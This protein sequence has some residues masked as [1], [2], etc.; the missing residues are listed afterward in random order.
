MVYHITAPDM[1]LFGNYS[2][3]TSLNLQTHGRLSST[4]LFCEHRPTLLYTRRASLRTPVPAHATPRPPQG[5]Q[6]LRSWKLGFVAPSSSSQ[7]KII[8]LLENRVRE[9]AHKSLLLHTPTG[10]A[11]GTA[12]TSFLHWTKSSA[13]RLS[14]FACLADGRAS[15]TLIA[16]R[17]D[18]KRDNTPKRWPRMKRLDESHRT[19][20][21]TDYPRTLVTAREDRKAERG[22]VQACRRFVTES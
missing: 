12:S 11:I 10:S 9:S 15:A 7:L 21:W 14:S 22:L 5:S 2:V 16:A 17:Q 20:T 13:A 19:L 1:R 3:Q 6:T 8:G 18:S 4:Q